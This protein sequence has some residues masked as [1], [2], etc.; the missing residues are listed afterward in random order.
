MGV[1]VEGED[2]V[3]Y[4]R[5]DLAQHDIHLSVF[6]LAVFCRYILRDNLVDRNATLLITTPT[7][8]KSSCT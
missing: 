8:R 5:V 4:L 1:E 6:K 2:M 3:E 7:V